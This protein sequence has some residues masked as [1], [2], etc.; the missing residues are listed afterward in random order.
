MSYAKIIWTI[1]ENSIS[2]CAKQD[3][4]RTYFTED[5]D[6]VLVVDSIYFYFEQMLHIDLESEYNSESDESYT[7]SQ[8]YRTD[9]VALSESLL[10]MDLFD[11]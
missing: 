8:G 5:D 3:I 1:L 2:S 10:E 11:L 7:K 6:Y 9:F 4:V